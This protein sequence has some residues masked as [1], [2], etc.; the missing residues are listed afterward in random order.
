MACRSLPHDFYQLI[1]G[2]VPDWRWKD[3][4]PYTKGKETIAWDQ[5][6]Q[7]IEDVPDS[8][9]EEVL[10]CEATGRNYRITKQ[11]LEFYR[12]KKLP[13]P[14]LHPDERHKRRMALRN[15]RKLWKRECD[16]CS[17]EIQTTY[18]PERPETIYCE[19]CYLKEVY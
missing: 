19:E 12:N 11:E 10:A 7:R 15:P 9:T 5:V 14:R 17:K 1:A 4:L 13:L 3:N 16:K 18:S 8:I 6:P 2:L